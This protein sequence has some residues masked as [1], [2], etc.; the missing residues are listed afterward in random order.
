MLD[1]IKNKEINEI[2]S[3]IEE[4]SNQKISDCFQCGSCTAGCPVAFAMD[5]VPSQAIR[6]LQFGMVQ[7]LL[8]SSG[9]WLCAACNVCGTRCPRGVDYAKISDALRALVLRSKKNRVEPDKINKD[10]IY[11]AP[12]QAFIA[13]FRKFVG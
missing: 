10:F 11:D 4:L 9:I 13:G 1:N 12:Q 5:P 3:S 8:D 7:E 2:I 6:M